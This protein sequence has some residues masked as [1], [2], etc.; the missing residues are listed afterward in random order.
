M[1]EFPSIRLAPGV[2]PLIGQGAGGKD[3]AAEGA[4]A[5]HGRF[6]RVTDDRD[7]VEG[8]VS[9]VEDAAPFCPARFLRCCRFRPCPR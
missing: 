2:R 9:L 6:G 8:E 4:L 3:A 7:I 1:A 5:G